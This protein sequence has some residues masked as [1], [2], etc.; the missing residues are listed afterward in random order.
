MDTKVLLE[1]MKHV[2][3][4]GIVIVGWVMSALTGQG[5]HDNIILWGEALVAS[6][7]VNF[8]VFQLK[9]WKNELTAALQNMVND[10]QL[11]NTETLE[12]LAT[13]QHQMVINLAHVM[14]AQ[15]GKL[16]LG[17]IRM[18]IV[19]LCE[20]FKWRA[21]QVCLSAIDSK[22]LAV[23]DRDSLQQ[24]LDLQVQAV[25]RNIAQYNQVMNRADVRKS[26]GKAITDIFDVLYSQEF[27]ANDNLSYQVKTITSKIHDAFTEAGVEIN[28]CIDKQRESNELDTML[29]N[30]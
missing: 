10:I 17:H 6:V 4:P 25:L 11:R 5:S 15:E 3:L 30:L 26:V 18:L 16:T 27:M 22:T 28:A 14:A 1:V 21:W 23:V 2:G 19:Y 8:V 12:A 9:D 20:A 24:A 29:K 13:N 7:F